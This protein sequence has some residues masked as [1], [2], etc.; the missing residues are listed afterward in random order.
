MIYEVVAVKKTIHIYTYIYNDIR[1][2]T[3]M[4]ERTN[5]HEEKGEN[6]SKCRELARAHSSID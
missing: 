4:A 2:K 6:V 3:N 1:N 5:Q